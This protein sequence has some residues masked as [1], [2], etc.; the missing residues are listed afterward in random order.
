ME[1]GIHFH[2]VEI[3]RRNSPSLQL[4]QIHVRSSLASELNPE[5]TMEDFCIIRQENEDP[6]LLRVA[7]RSPDRLEFIDPQDHRGHVLWTQVRKYLLQ[8]NREGQL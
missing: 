5:G 3:P 2:T 4:L 8:I 6:A 7:S 1:E